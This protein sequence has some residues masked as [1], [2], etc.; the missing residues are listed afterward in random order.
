MEAPRS[1]WLMDYSHLGRGGEDLLVSV[2]GRSE[3]GTVLALS[4]DN[5]SRPGVTPT[6]DMGVLPGVLGS[7]TLRRTTQVRLG[8]EPL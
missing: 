4:P 1:G 3:R 7:H 5:S 6:A 8:C 2:S